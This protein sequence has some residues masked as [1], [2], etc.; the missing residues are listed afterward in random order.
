MIVRFPVELTWPQQSGSPGVNVFHM[1]ADD[2]NPLAAVG[3]LS[4]HLQTFYNSIISLFGGGL[5]AKSG[6]PIDVD[7]NEVIDL[8]S[9][10]ST[11]PSAAPGNLPPALQLCIKWSTAQHT[12]RGT[13]RT[14][15]GPLSSAWLGAGGLPDAT[16]LTNLRNAVNTLVTNSKNVTGGALGVYGYQSAKLPA[17][18]RSAGDPRVLR[19][20]QAG[21]IANKF[22]VLRSRRD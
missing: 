4:G 15:I 16:S 7:T 1:R 13:G 11:S 22:A 10:W 3:S 8:A 12:R 5:V 6:Q 21:T 19:D 20:F 18:Q 2:S 14:F 17:A 9:P